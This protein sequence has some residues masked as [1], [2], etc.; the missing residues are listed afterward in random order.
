MNCVIDESGRCIEAT[1]A[2]TSGSNRLDTAAIDY[3]KQRYRWKPATRE[4]KPV[5]ATV[6][7]QVI[8]SLK[9]AQ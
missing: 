5:S 6:Q 9:D 8:W 4:G 1:V 3:V 7:I 2:K